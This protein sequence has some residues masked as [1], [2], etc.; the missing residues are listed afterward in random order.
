MGLEKSLTSNM[1]DNKSD[2][3]LASTTNNYNR[4]KAGYCQ[5]RQHSKI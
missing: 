5:T 2:A 3:C 1:S 4:S